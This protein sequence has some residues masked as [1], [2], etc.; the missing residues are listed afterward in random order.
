M[1]FRIWS[2]FCLAEV[3]QKR[4]WEDATSIDKHSWGYRRNVDIEDFQSTYELVTLLVQAVRLE[5]VEVVDMDACPYC[6]YLL[7]RYSV[8][9][10]LH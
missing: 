3:L 7:S 9:F 10:T 8:A 5:K 4:K 6:C 2:F 1:I